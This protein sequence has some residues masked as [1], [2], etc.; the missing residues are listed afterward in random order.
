M[1][2]VPTMNW[3]PMW[4]LN[5]STST[6]DQRVNVDVAVSDMRLQSFSTS[7]ST[8]TDLARYGSVQRVFDLPVILSINSFWFSKSDFGIKMRPFFRQMMYGPAK[9]EWLS[10]VSSDSLTAEP[11][12]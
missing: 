8:M 4:E 11:P 6:S 1:V 7:Y 12:S 3:R 2:P 5:G 9:R 10:I